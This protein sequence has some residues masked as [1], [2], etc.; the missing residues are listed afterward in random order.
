MAHPLYGTSRTLD[1]QDAVWKLP[2]IIPMPYGNDEE[3]SLTSAEYTREPSGALGKE[4]RKEE[5]ETIQG[6]RYST[7]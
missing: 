2:M 1:R 4:R 3:G 7:S 5:R 6:K